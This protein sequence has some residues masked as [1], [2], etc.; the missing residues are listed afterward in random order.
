MKERACDVYGTRGGGLGRSLLLKEKERSTQR[1]SAT[2][3][4]QLM[5]KERNT[6][7][8]IKALMKRDKTKDS[9]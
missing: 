6:L 7:Q 5:M 3:Q 2:W 1:D 4:N 8:M 9:A